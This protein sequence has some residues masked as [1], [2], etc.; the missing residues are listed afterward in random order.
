MEKVRFIIA[1]DHPVF[2]EGLARMLEVEE[3]FECVGLAEDGFDAIKLTKKT[4]PDIVLID[5]SMPN[6]M[7][8]LAAKEIHKA[9]PDIPMIM[10][11]AF[12]SESYVL[13]SLQAGAR[14]YILKTVPLDTLIVAIRLVRGGG[15]VLDPRASDKLVHHL[16]LRSGT[17]A[18]KDLMPVYPRELEVLKLAAR[19]KSNKEIA[20]A[21][22]ISERTV[23]T[24]LVNIFRKLGATSRTQAVLCA[25]REGWILL[26]EAG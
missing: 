11:S 14:G 26:D 8:T 18:G 16:S 6:L 25:L 4:E 23:Q 7:G 15:S 2:R 5:I 12:D 20:F 9:C 10:L 19:G 22:T 17:E 3:G 1:D 13:A 21:L 24:H